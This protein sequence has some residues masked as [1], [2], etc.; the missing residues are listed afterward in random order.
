MLGIE[1]DWWLLLAVM[2]ASIVLTFGLVFYADFQGSRPARP[3]DS[4]MEHPVSETLAAYAISL[5]VSLLLF[6]SFDRTEGTGLRAL[7]GM[8][9]MLGFVAS[10]GAAVGRL[11]VGGGDAG[12][13]QEEGAE[14]TS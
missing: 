2:V 9:V 11:L 8:T 12:A 1:A 6:W 7:L 4:P 3:G 13:P 10:L 5:G 14:G